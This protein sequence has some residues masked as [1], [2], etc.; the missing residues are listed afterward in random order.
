MKEYELKKTKTQV[1]E[2]NRLSY[3]K[4]YRMN[5]KANHTM[6]DVSGYSKAVN[7]N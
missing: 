2:Q 5:Q 1:Y 4:Q 6:W 7:Y 3:R